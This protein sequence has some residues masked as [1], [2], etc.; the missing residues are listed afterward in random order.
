MGRHLKS[1]R[2]SQESC[3]RATGQQTEDNG[4]Y[5]TYAFILLSYAV[6]NTTS[7]SSKAGR[8]HTIVHVISSNVF[9]AQYPV[10]VM[11]MSDATPF[12]SCSYLV[13]E[14]GG[15]MF[16]A[17]PGTTH[18]LD[19]SSNLRVQYAP[20][21]SSMA[22]DSLQD[23]ESVPSAHAGFY[24]RSETVPSLKLLQQAADR[25]CR[26]IFTGHSLG[27]A[28]ANLCALTAL[29]AQRKI[30]Q[31]AAS[32]AEA[33]AA[34]RR[35]S[36]TC[37]PVEQAPT[38]ATAASVTELNPNHSCCS[39][40][41]DY[42]LTPQAALVEVMSI[43]FASPVFANA[44]LAQWIEENGWEECFVNLVVPGELDHCYHQMQY[45][46]ILPCACCTAQYT[47]L[48]LWV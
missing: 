33:D 28:V 26:L 47:L 39:S 46:G 44:A 41:S 6:L 16:V 23:P 42:V 27:G 14:R 22:A 36:S 5:F 38:T 19:W 9:V 20:V 17:L 31:K 43:S 2:Y 25:G 30:Q 10:Q 18:P 45:S 37:Y 29:N 34:S 13:S 35:S 21:D 12:C 4:E 15:D 1:L 7:S 3:H 11:T 24:Y 48:C 8:R 32:K 40:N